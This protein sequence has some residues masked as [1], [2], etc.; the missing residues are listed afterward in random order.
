MLAYFSKTNEV[1]LL[2]DTLKIRYYVQKNKIDNSFD[3]L[4]KRID[5]DDHKPLAFKSFR[6]EKDANIYLEEMYKNA[7]YMLTELNREFN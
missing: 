6:E 2:L 4:F 1:Y 5:C 7:F 3:I